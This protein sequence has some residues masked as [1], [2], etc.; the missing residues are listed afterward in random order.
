[1]GSCR[2]Q[3][4]DVDRE[5]FALVVLKALCNHAQGEDFGLG[6]GLGSG[7]AVGHHAG[8]F[9]HLGQPAAV[10]F[11]VRILLIGL[12]WQN[13]TWHSLFSKAALRSL[14]H[15]WLRPPFGLSIRCANVSLRRKRAA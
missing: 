9:H 4:G 11:M 8:Q 3:D 6:N 7:G 1:M 15:L 14:A 2:D 12:A 5:R 13:I 10:G